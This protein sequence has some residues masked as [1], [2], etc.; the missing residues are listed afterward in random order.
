M[1]ASD[2]D[3]EHIIGRAAT[4]RPILDHNMVYLA[5]ENLKLHLLSTCFLVRFHEFLNVSARSVRGRSASMPGRPR[6]GPGGSTVAG[7][8]TRDDGA[9]PL[10]GTAPAVASV[11]LGLRDDMAPPPRIIGRRRA[12]CPSSAWLMGS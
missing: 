2:E 8:L 4:R 7:R 11:R 6:A 1:P 10:A 9:R 12:R 5:G 3:A